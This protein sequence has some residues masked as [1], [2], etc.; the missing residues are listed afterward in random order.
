MTTRCPKCGE[1]QE[2]PVPEICVSLLPIYRH[3]DPAAMGYFW[4]ICVTGDMEM[5][6][7]RPYP[8][9]EVAEAAARAEWASA[10]G[11]ELPA[12]EVIADEAE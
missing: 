3:E 6:G 11:T 9:R 5:Q 4:E 7:S 8:T 10:T 2:G 1:V 12:E